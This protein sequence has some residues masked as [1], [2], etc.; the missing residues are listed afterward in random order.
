MKINLKNY[1][2]CECQLP[3]LAL[4]YDIVSM[5]SG[6]NDRNVMGRLCALSVCVAVN[7]K[8]FPRYKVSNIDPIGFGG[9]CLEHLLNVGIPVNDILESGL[10]LVTWYATSLPSESE[11][12]EQENFTE[13][14]PVEALND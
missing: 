4:C 1:G 8:G 2:E 5:W 14:Q 12:K 7:D 11:V 13:Q 9:Q 3:S 6:N 10:K